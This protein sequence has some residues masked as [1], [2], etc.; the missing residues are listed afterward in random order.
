[1]VKAQV[2]FHSAFV[3]VRVYL[4]TFLWQFI[5]LCPFH[6]LCMYAPTQ[7]NHSQ[8]PLSMRIRTPKARTH[9]EKAGDFPQ[10]PWYLHDFQLKPAWSSFLVPSVPTEGPLLGVFMNTHLLF[11][12][13]CNLSM[14]ISQDLGSWAKSLMWRCVFSRL[15]PGLWTVVQPFK[16]GLPLGA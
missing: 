6:S 3:Y 2:T 11:L 8:C 15:G 16:E 4:S 1:M 14:F 13:P 12:F 10:C 7:S 9:V 5:L